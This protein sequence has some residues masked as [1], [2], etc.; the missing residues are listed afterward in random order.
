M[1]AVASRQSGTALTARRHG[2]VSQQVRHADPHAARAVDRLQGVL[3]H[4]GGGVVGDGLRLGSCRAEQGRA[5]EGRGG[6]IKKIK[7]IQ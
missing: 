4:G 1:L 7:H 5:G 2:P 3:Q 6:K